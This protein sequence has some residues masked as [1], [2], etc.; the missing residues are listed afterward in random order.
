MKRAPGN[1]N[2]NPFAFVTFRH[3]ASVGYAIALF[4][5]ISLYGRVLNMKQRHGVTPDY[6]YRDIMESYV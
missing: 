4:D 3:D 2:Q 5:G 1:S 6:K